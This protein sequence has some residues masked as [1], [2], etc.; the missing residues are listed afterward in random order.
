M[1]YFANRSF[2][3][4]YVHAALQAFASYGGEAFAFVYL[5][6]AGIPAPLVLLAIGA[7]FGSRMIFRQLVL[8]LVRRVGLRRA[9]VVAILAEAATYPILSQITGTGWLLFGYL[10]LWAL[11]SSLYWTTYHSY[12]AL[13][14]DNHARGKQTSAIELIGMGMGILAPVVTGVLLTAFSP[15]VAFGTVAAAMAL[16]TVPVLLGPEVAVAPQAE[17]PREARVAARTILFADGLRSGSFH[18]TWLIA[19]FLTLGSNYAAFGGAMAL[20]GLVGAVGGLFLGRAIDLGRGLGAA[21]IGFAALGIAAVAR[22]FGWP[23]PV[24]AV[25]ANAAA[26]LAWPLYA[27]AFNARVYN[28]ARQSPCPL[29][30]HIVAEGGWDLGTCLSCLAAAALLYMGFDFH[31]PLAIG[32]LA[33]GLGYL[34]I[35]R[36]FRPTAQPAQ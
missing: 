1:S 12:V 4:V 23:V 13:M 19:L 31:L 26:A 15:I 36:T 11:S 7:M 8:P 22:M 17:M 16:S 33:C 27:T 6:K 5:L 35:A 30:F 18:F 9:L 32:V 10:A 28:M 25:A 24:L 34:T 20:S 14:G 2:N 29:R 21:Q 3:L